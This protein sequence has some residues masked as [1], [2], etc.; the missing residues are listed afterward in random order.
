[1]PIEGAPTERKAAVIRA[2]VTLVLI[3]GAVVAAL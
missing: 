1:M 3:A 2:L